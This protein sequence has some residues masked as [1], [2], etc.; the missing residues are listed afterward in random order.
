M[1]AIRYIFTTALALASP[2]AALTPNEINDE[3][4]LY[5]RIMKEINDDAQEIQLK[6]P[7]LILSTR[8]H[9]LKSLKSLRS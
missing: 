8:V 7:L 6:D 5:S 3:I 1:V 4:W 9:S 2:I